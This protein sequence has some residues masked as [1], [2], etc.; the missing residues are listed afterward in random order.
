MVQQE[1]GRICFWVLTSVS[2][3]WLNQTP[4]SV[5]CLRRRCSVPAL[6]TTVTQGNHIP[7]PSRTAGTKAD[8]HGRWKHAV[9]AVCRTGTTP[10]HA[11]ALHY[12][13]VLHPA[14][15]HLLVV[16]VMLHNQEQTIRLLCRPSSI[17]AVLLRQMGQFGR[18]G[19]PSLSAHS[20]PCPL[21]T[22]GV[23]QNPRCSLHI[24]T[25]VEKLSGLLHHDVNVMSPGT[26]RWSLPSI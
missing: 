5:S 24:Q 19:F 26:V 1:T 13:S 25:Q 12:D 14:G 21:L 6:V 8:T 22:S 18:F 15:S 20:G 2:Q 4:A 23:Q 3:Q 9:S 16:G 7:P 17:F 10:P 11:A